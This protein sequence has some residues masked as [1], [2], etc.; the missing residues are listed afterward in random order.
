MYIYIH[1]HAGRLG[2]TPL[3]TRVQ[4][5]LFSPALRRAAPST[6]RRQRVYTVYP[7]GRRRCRR[8]CPFGYDDYDDDDDGNAAGPFSFTRRRTFFNL[9]AAILLPPAALFLRPS[10]TGDLNE[11]KRVGESERVSEM[12]TDRTSGAAAAVATDGDRKRFG[13]DA[14]AV[15]VFR[16]P[17]RYKSGNSP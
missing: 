12:E 4:R 3:R 1:T 14:R 7:S 17:R 2:L 10:R 8:V 16:I 5:P 13:G 6:T 15:A 11:R 9:S